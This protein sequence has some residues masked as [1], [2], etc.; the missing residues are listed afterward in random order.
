MKNLFSNKTQKLAAD[1]LIKHAETGRI[2]QAYFFS[3]EEFSF[4][5]ETN[6]SRKD[7]LVFD[8]AAHIVGGLADVKDRLRRVREDKHPDVMR[9]GADPDANSIKIE[10][11]RRLLQWV[12]LKAFE[13]DRKV[14]ILAQ[15]HKL[16][17]EAANAF[18]KTLEE[19]PGNTVF[20][21]L[22][23]SR[24]LVLE[25]IRS[26]CFEVRFPD[27]AAWNPA[28]RS[29]LPPFHEMLE[30][31][32]DLP[33]AELKPALDQAL[34]NVRER[35]AVASRTEMPKIQP[36]AYLHAFETICEAKSALEANAN[37]KL[38]VTRLVMKLR[39]YFAGERGIV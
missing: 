10:S 19:A 20:C 17:D 13:G 36:A 9:L 8:F 15:A 2:S 18:L 32:S 14:G 28:A 27:V 23:P 11:M 38:T 37:A 6:L 29:A 1:I 16:T 39:H 34:E 7:E 31:Y 3:G 30:N 33:K 25:T 35:L 26:R 22:A 5:P 21:L 4:D 12:S 24:E